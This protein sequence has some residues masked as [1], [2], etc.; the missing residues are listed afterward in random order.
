MKKIAPAVILLLCFLL[1]WNVFAD[2]F[3]MDVDLDGDIVDGPIGALIG[4]LFAG[5]GLII[6][7]LVV[8]LVGTVLAVVFAGVGLLLTLGLGIGALVLIAALS[9]LMLPIL[10][11]AAIIWFFMSRS[12]RNRVKT[13]AV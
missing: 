9:P 11:P 3:H 7:T 8:L 4:L 6:A 10:I 1:I 5:G 12:R 2:P 13:A